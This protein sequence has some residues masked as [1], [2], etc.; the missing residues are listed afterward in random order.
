MKKAQRNIFTKISRQIQ[1]RQIIK[2][3]AKRVFNSFYGSV[4]LRAMY[5][6]LD[7]VSVVEYTSP[8]A[9]DFN[10]YYGDDVVA[11]VKALPNFSVKYGNVVIEKDIQDT[12]YKHS[13]NRV[14]WAHFLKLTIDGEPVDLVKN[15][16]VASDVKQILIELVESGRLKSY[17][18]QNVIRDETWAFQ[19]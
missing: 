11:T 5:R 10:M 2:L 17:N 8:N 15:K 1:Y 16:L 19:R 3:R 9:T 13:G 4:A 18:A 7:L 12:F 14:G 6:N